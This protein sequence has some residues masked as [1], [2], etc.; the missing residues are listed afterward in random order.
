MVNA[1]LTKLLENQKVLSE[2][3]NIARPMND[4]LYNKAEKNYN[5][6]VTL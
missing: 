1:K 2:E 4:V 3:H 5:F 6:F